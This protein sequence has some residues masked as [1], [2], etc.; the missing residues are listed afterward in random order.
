MKKWKSRNQSDNDDKAGYEK[1]LKELSIL[2]ER[3]EKKKGYSGFTG[4]IIRY[5][6]GK[7]VRNTSKT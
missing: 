4:R 2:I 6:S 7:K 5:I 1:A 3:E